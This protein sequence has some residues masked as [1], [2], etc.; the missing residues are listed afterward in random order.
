[1]KITIA[2]A[3]ALLVGV[4]FGFGGSS[5]T[6][7]KYEDKPA[8]TIIDTDSLGT[9]FEACVRV[10]VDSIAAPGCGMPG[11]CV[12][13]YGM[14]YHWEIRQRIYVG[15]VIKHD[16]VWCGPYDSQPSVGGYWEINPADIGRGK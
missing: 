14:T 11:C 2:V 16:T 4:A 8:V 13:H 7:R 3:V 9:S 10:E 5:N 6:L 15:I 1:M 12:L